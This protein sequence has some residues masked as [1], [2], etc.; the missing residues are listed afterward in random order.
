MSLHCPTCGAADD[1]VGGVNGWVYRAQRAEAR[2]DNV[3]A[4]VA[5]YLSPG[6]ENVR[7]GDVIASI[8]DM[9]QI[10]VTSKDNLAEI[11]ALLAHVCTIVR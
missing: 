8:R 1:A 9:A 10:M 7:Q 2:L 4:E 11:K 3:R 6:N 5:K